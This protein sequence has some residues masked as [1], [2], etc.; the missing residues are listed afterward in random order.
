VDGTDSSVFGYGYLLNLE[1]HQLKFSNR[2]SI[3]RSLQLPLPSVKLDDAAISPLGFEASKDGSPIAP[4]TD[5]AFDPDTGLIE[6]LESVGE[7]DSRN[8]SGIT[9]LAVDVAPLF[10]PPNQPQSPADESAFN[11]DSST[12]SSENVGMFLLVPSGDNRGIYEI[13]RFIDPS[14]V[15][16]TPEFPV[17]GPDPVV[18][19]L[20]ADAEVIADRFWTEFQ[21]P[22]KKFSLARADSPAGPFTVLP[23]TEYDVFKNTGQVNLKTPAV[24]DEA[25]Q[26]TYVANETDDDGA[27]YYPVNKVE[28]ALFKIR[29]ETATAQG[30]TTGPV[31]PRE[32][33]FGAIRKVG[34]NTFTFNPDGKTV[35]TA[36]DIVVYV[37][38]M[39]LEPEDFT[40][41][42]PG[43]IKTATRVGPDQTVVL[44]YWVEDSPGG[45]TNFNLLS[46]AVDLDTPEVVEGEQEASYNGNQTD[47]LSPG[48]AMFIAETEVIIIQNS[49]Y[50][51]G[52][53]VTNVTF[54]SIPTVSS[55]GADILVTGP[56]N[57]SRFRLSETSAVDVFT[58]GT[59]ALF[60]SGNHPEYVIGTLVTVD[61]DPYSVLNAGYDEVT[62]KTKVITSAPAKR[63]YIIPTVTKT[64]R[65]IHFPGATFQT[66]KPAN[67]SLPFN[68]VR[69]GSEKEIL[70][71]DVDYV[72]SEGGNISLNIELQF[73]DEL[74]ATYVAREP[75]SI[76]TS[77]DLNYAYSIAPNQV[78]GITGQRLLA[79]YNLYAPDTFF[80]R[81]ETIESFIP[82]VI[83]L[84]QSSASSGASGPNTRDATGQA[85]KDYGSPSLYFEEQHQENLDIV[86][87][88]LLKLYNDLINIYEDILSDLD[89]RI[90]G[91]NNGRFR[92]DGN[93][94]NPVRSS[95]GEVTNDVDDTVKLYDT[96]QLTGFF[97]FDLV[98]VYGTMAVPNALSRIFPTVITKT[99]MINDETGFFD[100]GN[101]M[102]SFEQSN[103]RSPG[104]IYSTRGNSFFDSVNPAGTTFTIPKNGDVDNKLPPFDV[105]QD[106]E[107]Y[108]LDGILDV[109]GKVVFADTNEPATIIIDTPATI[110]EGSL[111]RNS[112]DA[113]NTENHFYA[114][115][116][117]LI[118]DYD[119]GQIYNWCLGIPARFSDASLFWM[120]VN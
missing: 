90:V 106:I 53:D 56:V 110:T 115:G 58:E 54:E 80:Y 69:M 59:N 96:I 40:F 1:A 87:A 9:G 34:T 39:L 89:G 42:A 31:P 120:G 46:D 49:E 60:I 24:P 18:A 73:G 98:P 75:Q 104:F 71:R 20:K 44:D 65:P 84:L 14:E 6:F 67:I 23:N 50:D 22:Y 55:E 12:F 28:N 10:V 11:S 85:N 5:F 88:R 27:T 112:N 4:G 2:R 36:R 52:E 43:T 30:G 113:G 16:V 74:V 61:D 100:L 3:S 101:T 78:N 21:P 118:L 7:N 26:I 72:L 37:N 19:D 76:G 79:T 45:N 29:Q 17:P 66:S 8:I 99:A 95:Y 41:E 82:E 81:V 47:V 57:G 77:F 108:T 48:S 114:A 15:R 63:N 111:L 62:G 94:D 13:T 35:N 107:V 51:S 86:M 38:G 116:R 33:K 70:T 102:G 32:K 91:G 93:F 103:I 109:S 68:L 97:S 92:F 64:A 25:F 117:D 105:D 83:D 119:N